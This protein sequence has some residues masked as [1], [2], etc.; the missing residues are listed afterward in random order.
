MAGL[1]SV[2]MVSK[3]AVLL[4][5]LGAVPLLEDPALFFG[6]ALGG[7]MRFLSAALP[8]IVEVEGKL[9]WN[10]IFCASDM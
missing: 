10:D 7:G 3:V 8:P 4:L 1:S 2:R 5:L 9:L 6:G